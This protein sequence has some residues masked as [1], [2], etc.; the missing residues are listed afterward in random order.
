MTVSLPILYYDLG[1]PYA[2]LAF[3]RAEEVLGLAPLLEPIL[4]GGIFVERGHGSWAHTTE[5]EQ[6]VEDVNARA[7][8]YRL[9]PILWPGAWPNNT[10]KAM[11]AAVW[12]DRRGCGR[13]FAQAAFRRAFREGAD[14]SR[15]DELIDIAESVGLAARQL[16]A[17]IE[18]QATKDA[19]RDATARAWARGVAGVPC[20]EVGGEIFYGDDRL[21]AARE[22]MDDSGR[23]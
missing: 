12:A 19:L 7:V 6:R 11:R 21:E 22:R 3:E 14:L 20:L 18:D 2:Y 1:S 13:P 9:P 17:A 4:V 16:P 23:V 10:L 8:R 15:L 5:R